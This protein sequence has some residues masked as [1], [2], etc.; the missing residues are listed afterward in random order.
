M[1]LFFPPKSPTEILKLTPQRRHVSELAGFA[2]S[3]GV[4]EFKEFFRPAYN[5]LNLVTV[6]Y[7]FREQWSLEDL[8]LKCLEIHNCRATRPD[9]TAFFFR[10]GD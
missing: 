3:F 1:Y 7:R 9:L 4:R 5:G 8:E 10:V 2:A 6:S